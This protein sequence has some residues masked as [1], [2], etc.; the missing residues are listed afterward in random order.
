VTENA[1]GGVRTRG[2]LL[3]ISPT[4]SAG[5][6][7]QQHFAVADL[8][9]GDGLKA[10]V[11]HATINRSL[12]SRGD[13]VVMALDSNLS[14]DAHNGI[15]DDVGAGLFQIGKVCASVHFRGDAATLPKKDYVFS[16]DENLDPH[17]TR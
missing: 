10:D 17:L 5:V 11:V 2:N 16:P 7:P 1:G 3:E 15:L 13:R 6:N 12:H 14:G 4:D 8:G 9:Y